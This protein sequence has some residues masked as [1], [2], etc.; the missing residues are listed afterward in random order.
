MLL[1]IARRD[2]FRGTQMAEHL[3]PQAGNP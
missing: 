3:Y 2:D 1:L